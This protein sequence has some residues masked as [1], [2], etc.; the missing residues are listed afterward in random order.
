MAGQGT[1]VDGEETFRS[2]LGGSVL[3]ISPR[4]DVLCALS[5]LH[6]L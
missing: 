3:T 5:T 4:T 6:Q 2:P 1:S